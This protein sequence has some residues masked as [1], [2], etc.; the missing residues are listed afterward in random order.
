MALAHAR[1]AAK[2]TAICA[3]VDDRGND[4]QN[5]PRGGPRAE[6]KSTTCKHKDVGSRNPAADECVHHSGQQ[7]QGVFYID[8]ACTA[9]PPRR[10]ENTWKSTKCEETTQVQCQNHPQSRMPRHC[11]RAGVA[12]RRHNKGETKC[13]HG[14][15]QHNIPHRCST[16]AGC[17]GG[18]TLPTSNRRPTHTSVWCK[19]DTHGSPSCTPQQPRR[20]MVADLMWSSTLHR[21]HQVHADHLR[22]HEGERKECNVEAHISA[23]RRD[24]AHTSP[25]NGVAQCGPCLNPTTDKPQTP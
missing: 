2:R 21:L 8:S 18:E 9:K 12:R 1:F 6:L 24:S 3:E 4:T 22:V 10:H 15:H 7:M 19:V 25:R 14:Q 17:E 16:T 11:R 23:H 13:R 5:T 20:C